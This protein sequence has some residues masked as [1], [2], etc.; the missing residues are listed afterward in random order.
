MNAYEKWESKDSLFSLSE[1][2]TM[3]YLTT[4]VQIAII[5]GLAQVIKK[6][7]CPTK[8]IPLIDVALGVVSGVFVFGL[9]LKYG[10]TEG[11]VMGIVMGLTAC[12]LFSGVKNTIGK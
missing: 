10:I 4:S 3:E 6:L 8:W 7:G 2:R 1:R 9:Y 12:G 5:I 11:I